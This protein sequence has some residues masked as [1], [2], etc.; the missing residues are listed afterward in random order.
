MNDMSQLDAGGLVSTPVLAFDTRPPGERYYR[1]PGDVVRVVMWAAATALLILLIEVAEG[2]NT[3]IREDLGEA[4]ALVPRAAREL[5]LG[6]A[7]LMAVVIPI[8]V[9]ALL[10]WQRRWRRISLIVLAAA[11]GAGA[12]LLLD[13]AMGLEGAVPDAVDETSWLLSTRFPP[14]AY[15]AGAA[16]AA[17]VGKPWLSREW[18]R[19]AD[20][21]LILLLA[22]LVIAGTS[23][24]AE[25]LLAVT[26]GSLVGS[27]LLVAFGAPNRRPSPQAIA[28]ALAAAGLP[29]VDL[30]LERAVGGRSQL[31]RGAMED[32]SSTF[33]KVYSADSRDADV[34]FRGYRRLI[35]R[36]PGDEW[37]AATLD[38]NVEHEGLLLL[39]ACRGGARCPELRGFTSLPD[40]SALLAMEDLRG[41]PLDSLSAEELD[42]GTLDSVW[43]QVHAFHATG[44]AHRA[45][46]AANIVVTDGGASIVDLSAATAPA[47]AR[48]QAIDR[49]E[50]LTS[51]ATVHGA[52]ASVAAAAR[53]LDA[54]ALAA[55]SPYVQP[56]ALSTAT[57]KGASKSTLKAIRESVAEVTGREPEKLE[58][59]VRVRPR[60]IFMI[61]TL[62]GAFYFLL[63]QL[64][65]VDDSVSALR[66]ANWGWIAACVV[67]SIL[68]Y[69]AAAVGM[70]GGVAEKLSLAPTTQVQLASS[71]VNRVTPANVGGMA[72]N[73]RYLQKAGVPPAEAVAGMGLNVVAGGIVH[74]VL[75]FVFFAWAGR[76][77]GEGFSLPSSSKVLVVIAVLLAVL[78]IA[79]ASRWGRKI[80]IRKVWPAVRQALASVGTLARSPRR[81]LLLF[82]GSIGV[83]LAY[84]ASLACAVNAF[85]ANVS[86]AQVGAVYL[87]SSII[88]AAAPTPGGLGAME[89]A[90]VAG[91]TAIGMDGALAVATV[92]S[93]RLAT[94]WLPILP[95]WIS[96]KLLERHNYI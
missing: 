13:A 43:Q 60:T 27:A 22:I 67:T 39:L 7:Q 86:F 38:R 31:Y 58:P 79:M 50:L 6:V 17:V 15:V 92:L 32:G 26:A 54:D 71:F 76:S 49:A 91:F 68:T 28:D 21:G 87:G 93:Y 45:L 11:A 9:L 59:L 62:T 83:T 25:V 42:D 81:L 35:L 51:L 65:N 41:R 33:I 96:L 55:A 30:T 16:A 82:G 77:G 89:A 88:A 57:R 47:D 72:L 24:L 69:V 75:L 90:L 94:Y 66:S 3:G 44:L 19:S 10:V 95:G 63:P 12:Y 74:I 46:R 78:G 29:A 5:A 18:R 2:T 40:G 70:V 52:D 85:D 84:V 80:V 8:V 20:R 73:V 4:A 53:T 61:A 37:P 1:H 56:L 34:L 23:G 36:E 64:A 14:V 48:M